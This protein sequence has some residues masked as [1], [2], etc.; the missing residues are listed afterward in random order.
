VTSSPRLSPGAST[1]A[2]GTFLLHWRL[3]L[4]S[5][6]QTLGRN[7]FAPGFHSGLLLHSPPQASVS[8]S[9]A[10][11][12][13]SSTPR[14]TAQSILSCYV[15]VNMLSCGYGQTY[16]QTH[17]GSFRSARQASYRSHQGTLWMSFRCGS[18]P[19][20]DQGASTAGDS[21][22]HPTPTRNA[23]SIPVTVRQGFYAA[24]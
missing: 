11:H 19:V 20:G 17:N 21:P 7:R 23:A 24:G 18:D 5:V 10:V 16:D 8:A 12:A 15:D 3:A 13:E 9:P 4:L 2:S 1:L 22:F 6:P 14:L